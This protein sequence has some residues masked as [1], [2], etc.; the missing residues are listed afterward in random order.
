MQNTGQGSEKKSYRV[1]LLLVVGLAAFS[2]AMKELNQVHELTLQTSSLIAQWSDALVPA[3]HEIL[4]RVD[5]CDDKRL[6]VPPAPPAPPAPVV[7]PPVELEVPDVV[8]PEITAPALVPPTPPRAPSVPAA[9]PKRAVRQ[10][11]D[12]AEVR[13]LISTEDF[14]EKSLRDSLDAD[15]TLKALKAKNRRHQIFVSPDG[16][17]IILKSLNRSINL[18]SAS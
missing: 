8:A 17:D 15:V 6:R 14:V 10:S 2:S 1:I 7:V 11:H 3:G 18:R 13:V 16:K 12:A 5:S 4:A 9:K